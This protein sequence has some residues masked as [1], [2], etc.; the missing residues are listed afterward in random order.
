MP[1]KDKKNKTSFKEG[2]KA[3][4]VWVYDIVNSLFLEMRKNAQESKDILCLQDAI[5]SVGLYSS[6]LDYLTNKFPDFLTIKKDIQDLIISRINKEALNNEFNATASIW[7]M[8][9]L[10]EIDKKEID[11]K[12]EIKD[13]S[14]I[15]K[16]SFKDTTK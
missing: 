5:H 9:Q 6:G 4:E 10:G 14:K 15:K 2:N 1:N 12:H 11:N 16:I 3:A 13:P 8:K 7:R